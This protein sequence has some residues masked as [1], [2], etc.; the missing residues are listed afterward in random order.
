MI[1]TNKAITN[2]FIIGGLTNLSVLIFSKFFNNPIIAE[3]DRDIMSNFGL[4]MIVIWGLA[5]ISVSKNFHKVK[6][7]VS[8]FAL[9][10]FI[11]GCVWIKWLLNHNLSEVYAKDTMAG[12]FYSVYG[13]NDWIFCFFFIWVFIKVT[14][15][16]IK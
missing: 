4:L 11:Y 2:T 15:G 8:V 1:R 5:Y 3:F 10:K 7:L 12:L 6:W 14:K 9:E 13:I 16:K